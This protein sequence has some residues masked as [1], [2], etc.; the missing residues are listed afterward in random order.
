MENKFQLINIS[1]NNRIGVIVLNRPEKRNALSPEL[2]EE[3]LPSFYWWKQWDLCFR[4]K[5]TVV[6]I[7]VNNQLDQDSFRRL[8]KNQQLAKSLVEIASETKMGREFLE[9]TY[10]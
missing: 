8:A 9:K 5:Q 7:Y 4:L 6:N 2:I 10:K 3:L 1:I